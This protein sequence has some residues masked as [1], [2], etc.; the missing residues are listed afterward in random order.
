MIEVRSAYACRS[1]LFYSKRLVDEV[2]DHVGDGMQGEEKEGVGKAEGEELVR[3][4]MIFYNT[5]VS[6]LGLRNR[7]KLLMARV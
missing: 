2:L 7:A 4:S 6:P 3:V 1:G 5:G